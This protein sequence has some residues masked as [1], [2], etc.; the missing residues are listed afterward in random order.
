MKNEKLILEALAYLVRDLSLTN[1]S[2]KGN[3]L[4]NKLLT[5]KKELK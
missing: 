4:A 1:G 2:D 3:A 5:A